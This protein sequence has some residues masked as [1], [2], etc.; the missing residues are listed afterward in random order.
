MVDS[1]TETAAL[2]A[3]AKDAT[4]G[5]GSPDSAQVVSAPPQ[6]SLRML[7]YAGPALS[8]M[9]AWI[10]WILGG[11]GLT[12]FGLVILAPVIWPASA[13]EARINGLVGIG[14]ALCAIL[15]VVV[16][17]LASGGLKRAEVRVG[18]AGI[19]VES[20]EPPA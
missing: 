1:A 15:G 7:A 3:A 6:L 11:V 9:I 4:T 10:I 13:A 19:V 2:L 18:P 5:L 16:Y 17:R 20:G 12:L 8:L 14:M